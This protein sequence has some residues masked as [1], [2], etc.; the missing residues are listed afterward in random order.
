[1][2]TL[3]RTVALIAGAVVVL[4]VPLVVAKA[5]RRP[6]DPR[7]SVGA[8]PP[9]TLLPGDIHDATGR[10]IANAVWTPLVS[11]DPRTG[12]AVDV[13]AE[14]ITSGDRRVWTVRL[15][16]GGRFHDG[17]AVTAR[18]YTGAWSAVMHA[19]WHGTRLLTDVARI[20][21]L[22][23]VDDRTFQ[24]TLGRPLTGFPLLL[25]DPAF[26]PLPDSVL[27]SRDWA[28]YGRVPVGNGPYRVRGA[29]GHEITLT[30]EG[31]RTIV[32]KA[33]PDA[34]RQY[35]AARAGDLDVATRVPPNRH[36]SM[37]ADFPRRHLVV[38]GRDLT[39]VGFP[40]WE[41]RFRSP[42][43]RRALSLA[44]DRV[45]ITEGA[46][47]HQ[48]DPATSLIPPGIALGRR[49]GQC[50]A[51]VHDP[52]A[53]SA[54]LAD[55]GG[56][57]GP[58]T[59]WY[60]AGSGDGPWVQAVARQLRSVLRLDV[61]PKAVPAGSF[62]QAL[63]DHQVDGPFASHVVADYPSPAAALAALADIPTGY[64]SGFAGDR[65]SAADRAA[66]PEAGVIPA[67]LAETTLLRDLPVVPLWSGHD[68]LVWSKRIRGVAAD[69]F[70]GLR[71]DRLTVE[72]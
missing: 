56:L 24:V 59:L 6:A 3:P 11:A 39:V 8:A 27:R 20:K 65:L 31:A 69:P 61:R 28:A 46:L 13:A 16:P 51:C 29:S 50:L 72:T 55:A 70:G 32:V 66:T 41:G 52:K 17:S 45:E 37:T 71:L 34:A 43:V 33:M 26:L 21:D 42:E 64:P 40:L 10:M 5:M 2:Q 12:A 15:R 44:I 18:S 63:G 49:Q 57:T 53:A 47:G 9:A 22:E 58:V 60:D 1:V 14:S 7:V 38:P 48:A 35:A 62:W 30:R 67:R 68:H 23:N 36:A 54:T 4:T 19:A 25:G